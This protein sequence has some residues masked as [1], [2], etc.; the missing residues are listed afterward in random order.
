MLCVSAVNV[1]LIV[2]EIGMLP[3]R[4]PLCESRILAEY[5]P[6]LAVSLST[7]KIALNESV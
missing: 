3:L 5:T 2:K 7:D 4:T 6:D 1:G